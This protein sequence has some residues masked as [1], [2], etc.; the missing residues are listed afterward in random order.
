MMKDIETNHNRH[1]GKPGRNA[2]ILSDNN[3]VRL[4]CLV[5][6]A[7]LD[8]DQVAGG[9]DVEGAGV[10]PLQLEIDH[11]LFVVIGHV[12][13]SNVVVHH[14]FSIANSEPEPI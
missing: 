14:I 8:D 2:R 11:V 7:G 1:R 10:G 5:E 3:K 6:P 12:D 13:P 9:E 4:D